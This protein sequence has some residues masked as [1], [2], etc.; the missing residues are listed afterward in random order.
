MRPTPPARG[1]ARI[2][3]VLAGWALVAGCGA[4]RPST[5]TIDVSGWS[6][7]EAARSSDDSTTPAGEEPSRAVVE[8]LD[9]LDAGP[10]PGAP[11][12]VDLPT[13]LRFLGDRREAI[14]VLI[15]RERA[16]AASAATWS[17][18][19]GMV[20]A[21]KPRVSWFRHE[22]KIQDTGGQFLDVDKQN[23]FGG[24]GIELSVNPGE[25]AL[26]TLAASRRA[27]AREADLAAATQESLREAAHRYYD[28]LLATLEQRIHEQA[29]R[30]AEE[31][32][33]VEDA[34][35]EQGIGLRF[36]ALRARA[37]LA[38]TRG[39]VARARGDVGVASA[40]LV[41]LLRLDERVVL[42]PLSEQLAPVE[43]LEADAGTSDLVAR[44]RSRRPE[45]SSAES[46]RRAFEAVAR[47]EGLGW[48]MPTV[49]G[50]VS[51][52][53]F[54]ETLSGRD[55]DDQ[56]IYYLA[57]ELELE[58]GRISRWR[59]ASH[60]HREAELT[61]SALENRIVA[62]VVES[63][64]T[65]RAARERVEAAR[66]QAES[67]GEAVSISEARREAGTGLL[68]DVLDAQEALVRARTALTEAL[69]T[70][71][72]GQY[73]LLRAVGGP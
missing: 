37:R 73:D 14:D 64:E 42:T 50:G 70:H 51:Y 40:R 26:D 59:E 9:A 3:A 43:F 49:R 41:E 57:L 25:S 1:R 22:G 24:V 47:R 55:T 72:R 60:R 48:L 12:A 30:R 20:P 6:P 13:V 31:L 11:F 45:L 23:A 35:V 4:P 17:A 62:E 33:R 8:R 27:R 29:Q 65:V 71:N 58:A 36:D 15:A 38:E 61:R 63:H 2:V 34:R 46:T 56:E 67:A 39:D 32:V 21:V 7:V 53:E 19:L 5:R 16:A 52:G 69:V 68:I 10:V 28:L 66:Q 54:G 18:A 44:A